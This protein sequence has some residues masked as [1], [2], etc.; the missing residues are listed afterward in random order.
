MFAPSLCL[1][2][3]P[4]ALPLSSDDA[5]TAELEIYRAT[6]PPGGAAVEVG[7][8]GYVKTGARGFVYLPINQTKP[9]C[10]TTQPR[11]DLFDHLCVRLRLGL[12]RKDVGRLTLMWVVTGR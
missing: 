4:E 3:S 11:T 5:T 9:G 1:P 8:Q 7:Q 6:L 12:D 10:G 2:P